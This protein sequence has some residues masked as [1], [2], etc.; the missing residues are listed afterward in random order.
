MLYKPF[1]TFGFLYNPN[2]SESSV[3]RF[4]AV[5]FYAGNTKSVCIMITLMF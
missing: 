4:D 3:A 1:V 5:K 2:Y